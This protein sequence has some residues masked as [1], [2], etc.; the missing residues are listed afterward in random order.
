MNTPVIESSVAVKTAIRAIVVIEVRPSEIIADTTVFPETP[1]GN[2]DAED[3]FSE[4]LRVLGCDEDEIADAL[5]E[6]YYDNNCGAGL[7]LSHS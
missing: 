3:Y 2:K 1:Q 6:G 4:R 5:E 7:Q